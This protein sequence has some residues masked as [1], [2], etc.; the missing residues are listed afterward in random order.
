MRAIETRYKGR[1]FRSRLE[2]RYAV[3]FDALE[4]KWD[5]EPEGYVLDSGEHYLPDFF[6][7]MHDRFKSRQTYPGAGYW[8]E[9]KG[10]EPTPQEKAKFQALCRETK[11]HGYMFWGAPGEGR[12]IGVHFPTGEAHDS[13]PQSDSMQHVFWL[14]SETKLKNGDW[15][16][17]AAIANS[18][19]FEFNERH[20]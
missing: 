10:V 3:L 9:I 7:H 8:C 12:L 4:I 2:A 17:Y 6:L 18:T 19:R 16:S 5:Y 15:S 13:K 11:H 1:R 20:R 14:V